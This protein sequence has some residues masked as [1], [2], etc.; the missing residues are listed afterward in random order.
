MLFSYPGQSVV[1]YEEWLWV[2]E[3]LVRLQ[4]IKKKH[5]LVLKT[6]IFLGLCLAGPS[7]FFP[8]PPSPYMATFRSNPLGESC[9][10]V[11][12]FT[13]LSR[14]AAFPPLTL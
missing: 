2:V 8:T 12:I 9:F 3:L 11:F 1:P 14:L 5:M 7:Q 10:S 13:I 6:K 4:D